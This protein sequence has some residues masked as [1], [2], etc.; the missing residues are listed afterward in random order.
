LL[1]NCIFVAAERAQETH[2]QCD[3]FLHESA[4]WKLA[5]MFFDQR[6]RTRVVVRLILFL[7]FLQQCDFCRQ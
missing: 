7:G 2:A 6:Q 1:S 3:S 4:V 5:P